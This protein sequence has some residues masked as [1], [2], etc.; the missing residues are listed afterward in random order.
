[1]AIPASVK[2]A[3]IGAGIHGLSTAYHLAQRLRA[4]GRGSGDDVLVIDKS[5]I[6][7]G[8]SG[9]ACGVVRNN[10]YQ[11]AMRALMA[12]CVE[13]WE[14]DP[15][16]YSY[17]PVGYMQISPEAMH[18]QVAT[19]YAQQQEIGY[20]SV[21][22]EGAA[23]CERYMKGLF[24]DWQAKGITSVLHEK[25]GGYANNLASLYGLA[26]KAESEN[27]RILTGVE[28]TGFE[29]GSNSA[30][31][32]ALVTD[33][34]RIACD[35]V[36]VALGPWV[37]RA[38]T[39]LE[40]PKRISIKGTD[41][42]IHDGVPM[43]TYWC[44]EEG[45]LGVDP[46][47]HKTNDG[48]MPP[49]IHVDTD[50]PLYSDVDGSLITDQLWG[51]YYKPDFNF[52]GVQ[53][54][55]S[56]YKVE[57]DADEVAVDPYGPESPDFIVGDEFVHTWCSMLAHCQ[58]RFEGKIGLYKNK[59]P[60]GGLG[61]FTPDNFPVFDVFRENVY[62]IADSNHGYKMIGVGKLVA[63]EILGERSRLLE[64]FR[65]SRYAEGRLHPV[66]N[67]PFPWS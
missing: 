42:G 31:V 24:D 58:K 66:S 1:M 14:S 23:D 4:S 63:G 26:A 37:S 22:I 16:A 38:W 57:G 43:W 10:Y 27:V 9:I 32:T 21:F 56:P 67:S 50:A 34:G 48:K 2:F 15:E 54:G 28:V 5:A 46:N 60:S 6:G 52:G 39:M 65:F 53:G 41:G 33:K 19:I 30:A 47:I 35:H 3:V 45:T 18:R 40:L 44:L 12:H 29:F 7:A 11:P 49:V 17:H 25:K 59:E 13:V 51:L 61:C 62:V 36:V 20:D 64:P 8:A 55:S